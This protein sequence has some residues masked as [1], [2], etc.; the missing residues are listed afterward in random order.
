MKIYYDNIIFSLQPYGGGISVYWSELIKQLKQKQ[1][2]QLYGFKNSNDLAKALNTNQILESPLN[3]K[4]LRYCRFTKTLPTPSIFHSSYYRVALQKNIINIVTVHDFAYERSVNITGLPKYI[5]SWQKRSAIKNSD[6]IICISENTKKDLLYFY[7]DVPPAKIKVIYNGVSDVFQPLNNP[8]QDLANHFNSLHGK[9]YLL[10]VGQ[11][12]HYKNFAKAVEVIKQMPDYTLVVAGGN[13]LTN[14]EKNE[15]QDSNIIFLRTVTVQQLNALY[16]NAFCLL[17]PSC[18]EGFGLP[19]IEA[20]QAGCPVVSV[21]VSS[22]PEVAGDAALLVDKPTAE[23]LI[24]AIKKLENEPFRNTL[25]N[26]G[27]AQAQKFNW[28]QCARE[29]YEFYQM[30]WQK[31]FAE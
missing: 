9:K 12:A 8:A 31:R 27:L 21:N 24:Q 26:K 15:Y 2:L 13:A 11:R 30:I 4:L 20:M 17:Y 25:I 16:N 7:P 5:H 23:T 22:I 19:I 10:Y 28:E 18:Y 3:A 29:T 14:A 6:G 1:E